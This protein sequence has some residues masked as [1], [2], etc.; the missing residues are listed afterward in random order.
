[1]KKL[2]FNLFPRRYITGSPPHDTRHSCLLFKSENIILTKWLQKESF[3][4]C[5]ISIDPVKDS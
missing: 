2:G 3:F 5:S 4:S 1:M